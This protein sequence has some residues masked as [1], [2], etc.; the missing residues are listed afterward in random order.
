MTGAVTDGA[1]SVIRVDRLKKTYGE[2]RAVDGVSFEVRPG[3][4]FGL[5]G[6]N[7]AG[8]TTTVEVLEGLRTPDL[9]SVRVLGRTPASANLAPLPRL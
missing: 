4:V 7:G 3:T 5:L 8:K 9:G 2:T 1:E 6:P